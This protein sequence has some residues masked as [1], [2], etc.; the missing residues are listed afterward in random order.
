MKYLIDFY[1]KLCILD[2]DETI[3]T[4]LTER[5]NIFDFLECFKN[6]LEYQ[7]S[8]KH[9]RGRIDQPFHNVL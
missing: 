8:S 6:V 9:V 5:D 4:V 7:N 2:A 3:F 1:E